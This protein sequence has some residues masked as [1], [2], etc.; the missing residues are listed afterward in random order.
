MDPVIRR[1]QMMRG[2]IIRDGSKRDGKH[3]L[4]FGLREVLDTLGS[5]AAASRWRCSGVRYTSKD[6]QDIDALERETGELIDGAALLAATER[7]QQVIDGQFEAIENQNTPWVVVRAVDSSWW[8]VLSDEQAVLETVRVRFQDV[9][10]R[11][12]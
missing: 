8:E 6:E 12:S 10:D 5:R 11:P 9:E 7:L 2:V 3:T 1:V 4:D